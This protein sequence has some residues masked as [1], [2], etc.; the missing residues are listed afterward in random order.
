MCGVWG[1]F[2][3]I[4]WFDLFLFVFGRE[5][6]GWGRESSKHGDCFEDWG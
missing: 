1:I 5:C 2:N 6:M 4:G 3:Y